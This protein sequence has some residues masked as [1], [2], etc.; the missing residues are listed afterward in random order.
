MAS[1]LQTPTDQSRHMVAQ[2][3]TLLN[4]QLRKVLK[5]EGLTISGV[6]ADLQTRVINRAQS[7][8]TSTS[9]PKRCIQ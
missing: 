6:K 2:T 5:E 9:L 7:H 1:H 4:D 8:L 3:K